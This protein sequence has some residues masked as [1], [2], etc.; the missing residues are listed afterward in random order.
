MRLMPKFERSR[1]IEPANSKCRIYS[2]WS[3]T[4]LTA[5][6][7]TRLTGGE[8]SS[9]MPAVAPARLL[10]RGVLQLDVAGSTG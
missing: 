10:E 3:R 7:F 4:N 6:C 9:A 1:S 2:D 8:I 5:R